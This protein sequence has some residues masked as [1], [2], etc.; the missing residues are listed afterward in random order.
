MSDD[1]ENII[2]A[3]TRDMVS[4]G[5]EQNLAEEIMARAIERCK[6]WFVPTTNVV[7]FPPECLPAVEIQAEHWTQR[8]M[9]AF[10][11]CLCLEAQLYAAQ[12]PGTPLAYLADLKPAGRA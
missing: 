2:K 4:L 9:A 12:N 8:M 5:M 1:F 7:E 6:D 11:T 3:L 10:S